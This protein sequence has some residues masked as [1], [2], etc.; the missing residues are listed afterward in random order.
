MILRGHL[1]NGLFAVSLAAIAVIGP[2]AA[3]V[4]PHAPQFIPPA[5]PPPLL[6]PSPPPVIN[7]PGQQA[8]SPGLIP[9]RRIDTHSDRTTRCLHA[10]AGQ[11]LRGAELD[12]YTRTCA[13]N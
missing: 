7:G 5:P 9:Q 2:A 4:N 1:R 6:P 12:A 13:N 11:G 3:Q 8:P 10:G